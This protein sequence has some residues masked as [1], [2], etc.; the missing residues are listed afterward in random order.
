MSETCEQCGKMHW[1]AFV[2]LPTNQ[3]LKIGS[4][5]CPGHETTDA[6]IAAHFPHHIMCTGVG[7]ELVTLPKGSSVYPSSYFQ[8]QETLWQIAQEVAEKDSRYST[9][10]DFDDVPCGWRCSFCRGEIPGRFDDLPFPH[11]ATCIVAKARA[12]VEWRKAQPKLELTFT[13][14][15]DE[16]Y[17]AN[18]L[19]HWQKVIDQEGE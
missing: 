16:S 12:L 9:Y 5:F 4:D 11:D 14:N 13:Q 1:S 2:G 7:P 15:S 10:Q 6:D 18:A 17:V 3:R 19:I 8:Q